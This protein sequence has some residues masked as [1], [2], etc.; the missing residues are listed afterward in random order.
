MP[1]DNP[2]L[3]VK[4]HA[5]KIRE[6]LI[7]AARLFYRAYT[8]SI[9]G[10]RSIVLPPMPDWPPQSGIFLWSIRAMIKETLI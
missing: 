2:V 1:F 4:S 8:R 3:A 5:K 6:T 10:T 7:K 9:V